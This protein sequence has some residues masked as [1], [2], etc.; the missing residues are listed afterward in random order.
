M[1]SPNL[2]QQ[3]PIVATPIKNKNKPFRIHHEE[4]PVTHNS[5]QNDINLDALSENLSSKYASQ[6][7]EET[8]NEKQII[9]KE[10]NP[11][12]GKISTKSYRLVNRNGKWETELL[13]VIEE[14]INP[15]KL[16]IKDAIFIP[17]VQ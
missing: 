8:I 14:K 4:L 6:R 7:N 17:D 2:K 3:S 10:E 9:V 1:I 15:E 16:I 13:W 11:A 5:I 12:I